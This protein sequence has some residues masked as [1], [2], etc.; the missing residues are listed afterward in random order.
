LI[1]LSDAERDSLTYLKDKNRQFVNN[2]FELVNKETGFLPVNF[3][4][5][6]FGKDVVLYN[7]LFTIR[8]KVASLLT[9]INDTLA[10]TG[11]EAYAAASLAVYEYATAN[12][13][14]TPGI[15]SYV[16]DMTRRFTRKKSS[17]SADSSKT[18]S[19]AKTA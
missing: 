5:A 13:V 11:S 7:D 9:R 1:D 6:K 17:K 15:D 12:G 19:S 2:S 3:S 16:D 8:Q 18:S 14:S 4:T 10:V